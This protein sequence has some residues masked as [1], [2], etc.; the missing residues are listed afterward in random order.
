MIST[1]SDGCKERS[2]LL[3]LRL[4]VLNSIIERVRMY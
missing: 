3:I 2:T 1:F 4:L